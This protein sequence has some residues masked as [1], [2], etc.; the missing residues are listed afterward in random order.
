MYKRFLLSILICDVILCLCFYSISAFYTIQLSI[1]ANLILPYLS[2]LNLKRKLPKFVVAQKPRILLFNQYE[3]KIKENGFKATLSGIKHYK[4]FLNLYKIL[5]YIVFSLFLIYLMKNNLFN[6]KA[7]FI[8]SFIVLVNFFFLR[9][10]H[11]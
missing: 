5:A 3:I 11:V 4:I 10:K 1:M 8:T 7:F 6:V 2:F 9:S